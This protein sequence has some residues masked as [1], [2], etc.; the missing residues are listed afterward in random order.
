MPTAARTR[1]VL[2]GGQVACSI[3]AVVAHNP[4]NAGHAAIDVD[5]CLQGVTA[6]GNL[7]PLIGVLREVT[8]DPS[9]W[10]TVMMVSGLRCA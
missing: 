7:T 6:S 3:L 9:E 10:I 8:V 4:L 1:T 2:A 5:G